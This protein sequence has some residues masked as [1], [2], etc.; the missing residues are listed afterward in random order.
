MWE[1]RVQR[2]NCALRWKFFSDLTGRNNIKRLA[3]LVSYQGETKLLSSQKLQAKP[4][5]VQLK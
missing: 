5:V 3:I 2:V 4:I 1:C